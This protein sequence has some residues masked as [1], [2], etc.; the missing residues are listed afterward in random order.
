MK[1]V[2]FNGSIHREGNTK[3]LIEHVLA[4]IRKEGIDTE[5][6]QQRRPQ[7]LNNSMDA[8]NN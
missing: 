3:L 7:V 1:V 2:A 8:V 6:V 5:I 4:E